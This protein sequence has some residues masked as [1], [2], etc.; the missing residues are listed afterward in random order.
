M[1]V[2][3][4]VIEDSPVIRQLIGV[5]LRG[6]DIEV[7]TRDDGP[8]GLEAVKTES[9]DLVI[10]DIGLPGMN[11]WQVLEAIRS[12]PDT[13]HLPVVVL[14]AHAQEDCQELADRAGADV[15]ITKP[16]QIKEFR[17]TVLDRIR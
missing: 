12:D 11:G 7:I 13:I 1:S 3:I 4:L 2:R 10:L 14:T 16:F 6:D 15:V 17:A 9:P 8:R 5:C